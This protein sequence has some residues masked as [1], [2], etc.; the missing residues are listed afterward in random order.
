MGEW[1]ALVRRAD[2]LIYVGYLPRTDWAIRRF[3]LAAALGRPV[4]RWWVGTDVYNA[5]R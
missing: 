3:A 2:L 5:L 1:V 4:V